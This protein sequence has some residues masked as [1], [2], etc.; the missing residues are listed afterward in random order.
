MELLNKIDNLLQENNLVDDTQQIVLGHNTWLFIEHPLYE[1]IIYPITSVMSEDE[2]E[3]FQLLMEITREEKQRR[4]ELFKAAKQK[5][6][7][8]EYDKTVEKA[9]KDI[10]K[11]SRMAFHE[12][13]ELGKKSFIAQYILHGMEKTSKEVPWG[14]ADRTAKEMYS[15][16][17]QSYKEKQR[18]VNDVINMYKGWIAQNKEGHKRLTQ[19]M[20]RFKSLVDLEASLGRSTDSYVANLF[21]YT[22]DKFGKGWF[23]EEAYL[24]FLFKIRTKQY[25]SINELKSCIKQ[26]NAIQGNTKT[27]WSVDIST[28]CPKR[29]KLLEMMK[30]WSQAQDDLANAI[31]SGA[32]SGMLKKL[33]QREKQMRVNEGNNPTCIYCYVE[34]AR[35]IAEK[36]P[37]FFLAKAEKEG[38]R[39]QDTFKGWIKKEKGEWERDKDG[40]IVLNKVGQK[41]VELFNRM[42]GLRFFSSG[43]Y[44]E[45]QAT[46]KEIERII[47]DAEIVGLQL[48][49]ITKS[50]KFVKKFG[51]RTFS[52]GPLRGRPIFNINMSV[53]EQ[54]GFPLQIAKYYKK[55]YPGNV[56]IRVV[57]FNPTQ[58]AKYSKDPD[59]DVITLLHFAARGR[60]QNPDLYVN[61]SPGSKGWKMAIDAMKEDLSPG[62]VNK[63][64]SKLCCATSKCET[65][66]NACGFNPRRVAD[67]T[68]LAKG[69]KK[70]L[71]TIV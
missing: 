43:D 35:A 11:K 14:R 46:D 53:D 22:K 69:G 24:E 26:W 4:K 39:Y 8:S 36:N 68:Q 37:K 21:E 62:V 41:N 23:S 61:M 16:A 13:D 47:S 51:G 71:K 40:N 19:E 6:P 70:V 9:F 54:R 33:E 29:K 38:L 20:G 3:H 48:K 42:G 60:M 12:L 65:C 63:I 17:L 28:V 58:A 57:A 67:Y 2:K 1:D 34:S 45:D 52:K 56:N 44:I 49:A 7:D 55:L 18:F 30:D 66:P 50:D 5:G 27:T 31:E 10:T 25:N 15:D 32:E 59:V 64:L